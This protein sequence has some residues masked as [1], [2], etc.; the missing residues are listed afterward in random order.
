MAVIEYGPDRPHGGGFVGL[1]VFVKKVGDK[2]FQKYFSF[3]GLSDSQ[4]AE[5]RSEADRLDQKHTEEAKLRL[6]SHRLYQPSRSPLSSVLGISVGLVSRHHENG[7]FRHE[8][9]VN[10]A[11]ADRSVN[12]AGSF[13]RQTKSITTYDYEWFVKAWRK[14][15]KDKAGISGLRRTPSRWYQSVPSEKDVQKF[16]NDKVASKLI[17]A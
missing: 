1:R 15:C 10:V 6:T 8:L 7:G 13:S 4:V 3:K 5:A 9:V 11:G 17:A 16:I 12:K 2:P 14:A